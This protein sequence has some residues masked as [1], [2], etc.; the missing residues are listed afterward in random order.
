MYVIYYKFSKFY[1]EFYPRSVPV[2]AVTTMRAGL[3][4]PQQNVRIH[5]KFNLSEIQKILPRR[6]AC[7]EE[8]RLVISASFLTVGRTSCCFS[9]HSF[10]KI[11]TEEATSVVHGLGRS[12]GW[13]E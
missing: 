8:T 10:Y 6:I 12:M 3:P 13:V 2:I 11:P 5:R 4:V 7:E 1:C 9:L